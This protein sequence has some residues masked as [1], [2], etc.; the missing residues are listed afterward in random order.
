MQMLTFLN[1]S[2]MIDSPQSSEIQSLQFHVLVLHLPSGRNC[3]CETHQAN[4]AHGHELY[5]MT[6][7]GCKAFLHYCT[8]E[9][10]RAP[11]CQIHFK[12]IY[13]AYRQCA[14]TSPPLRQPFGMKELN[15][16]QSAM[17]NTLH[18]TVYRC[19]LRSDPCHRGTRAV[20]LSF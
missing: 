1:F 17:R 2:S 11:A 12:T 10:R 16:V 15:R 14:S 3:R 8:G 13:C 9:E 20:N 5:G 19:T 6:T 18:P 7:P 4:G